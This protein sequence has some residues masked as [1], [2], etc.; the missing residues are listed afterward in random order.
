MKMDLDGKPKVGRTSPELGVRGYDKYP[1]NDIDVSQ[2]EDM[3]H[4]VKGLSVAPDDPYQLER[5]RRPP[6]FGGSGKDPLWVL[7]RDSLGPDVMY[8][9]DTPFHGFIAPNRPMTLRKYETALEMT[10][11]H[12]KIVST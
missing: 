4:P 11:D 12:W 1:H 10:R 6:P 7:D 2:P 9:I 8:L 3:V 5:H